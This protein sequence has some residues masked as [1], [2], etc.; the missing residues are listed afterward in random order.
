MNNKVVRMTLSERQENGE[1]ALN[2]GGQND[3]FCGVSLQSGCHGSKLGSIP[4]RTYVRP[5]AQNVGALK[6]GN[7]RP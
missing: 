7:T 2:Q 6:L 1:I 4:D 5:P 3:R